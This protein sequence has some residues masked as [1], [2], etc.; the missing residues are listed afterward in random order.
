MIVRAFNP[1]TDTAE[2][3]R[4][5]QQY[6]NEFPVSDLGDEK[7]VICTDDD[8]IITIGANHSLAELRLATDKTK[9][10]KLRR[11]ALLRSLEVS[12]FVAKRAGYSQLHAFVQD[13]IWLN[14]LLKHGFRKTAGIAILTDI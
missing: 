4:I 12:E 8:E 6:E 5:H 2:L 1:E 9:S 10:V 14:Q 13:K 11:E 3:S 7:F